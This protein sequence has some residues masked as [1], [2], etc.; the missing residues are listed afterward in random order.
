MLKRLALRFLCSRWQPPPEEVLTQSKH[1]VPREPPQKFLDKLLIMYKLA[2]SGLK[3]KECP[4]CPKHNNNEAS[5]LYTL[6][7]HKE[8]GC[9]HCFR[10][11]ESGS[12]LKLKA[13][14]LGIED[15]SLSTN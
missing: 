3:I 14:L 2:P 7:V 1:Y 6:N 10:C 12:Y 13:K 9:F 11:S 5:N 8:S 4:F 15:G